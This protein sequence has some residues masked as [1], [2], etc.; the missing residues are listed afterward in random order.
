MKIINLE[1]FAYKYNALKDSGLIPKQIKEIL[2]KEFDCKDTTYYSAL[3]KCR[4]RNFIT[5][6]WSETHTA[7]IIRQKNDAEEKRKHAINNVP[8][9]LSDD[10][11]SCIGKLENS[12]LESPNEIDRKSVV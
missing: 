3:R 12:I 9:E 6:S 8:V 1:D 2:L 11:T 5:D 4:E 7:H 10:M